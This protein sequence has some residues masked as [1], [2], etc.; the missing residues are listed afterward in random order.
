MN[1]GLQQKET[2]EQPRQMNLLT[3][4]DA[5]LLSMAEIEGRGW[6][7]E[8]EYDMS[9]PTEDQREYGIKGALNKLEEMKERVGFSEK[10]MDNRRTSR[11]F[12]IYGYGGYHRYILR[13]NG[14]V[15]FHRGFMTGGYL[16]ADGKRPID[17]GEMVKRIQ[18]LG[19]EMFGA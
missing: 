15:Q 11:A 6:L 4:F 3:N 1:E 14:D 19:F 17:R 13:P 8:Q 18:G 5:T 9:R 10:D 16:S 2:A 12:I 7:R